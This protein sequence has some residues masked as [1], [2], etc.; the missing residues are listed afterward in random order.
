[1]LLLGLFSLRGCKTRENAILV[2]DE[3]S[4]EKKAEADCQSPLAKVFL[5]VPVIHP[6]SSGILR[7]R[8]LVRLELTLLQRHYAGHAECFGQSTAVEIETYLVVVS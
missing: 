1:M 3:Q 5:L 2:L 7:H 4:S 6:L 8:S